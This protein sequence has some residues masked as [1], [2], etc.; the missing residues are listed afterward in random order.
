[1]SAIDVILE[2][3]HGVKQTGPDR[4]ISRC[5]AH[6]DSSPSLSIRSTGDGRVLL[7]CF[8]GCEVEEILECMS[9]SFSAL[10]DAPSPHNQPRVA[11]G[12]SARELL[13]LIAHEA[14]VAVLLTQ[15]G[16]KRSLTEDEHLRL[17][18]A[19]ARISSALDLA[20]GA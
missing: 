1:L 11:R 6:D 10:F 20:N 12:W 2:R 19:S 16:L 17:M 18:Q 15:D 13:E 8:G 7:H 5:P 3:L 14:I 9:L 4:W